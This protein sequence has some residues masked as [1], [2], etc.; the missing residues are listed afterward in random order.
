M[1]FIIV[2]ITHKNEEN[3]MKVVKHLLDKKLIACANTFPIKSSYIWNS[4][5][6]NEDEIVTIV[7]TRKENWESLRSEVEKIHPYETPCI[8]RIDVTANSSYEEWIGKE[9]SK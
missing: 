8:M 1:G 9:T 2:Y 6:A 3:A 5:I 7:K 4:K